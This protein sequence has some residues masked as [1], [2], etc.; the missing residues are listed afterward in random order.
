VLRTRPSAIMSEQAADIAADVEAAGAPVP[1]C[2]PKQHGETLGGNH[3]TSSS[4]HF[5]R[6]SVKRGA[7]GRNGDADARL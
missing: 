2:V 7:S 6:G 1:K 4:D 3:E 5:G